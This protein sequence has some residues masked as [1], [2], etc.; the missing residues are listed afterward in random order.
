[1]APILSTSVLFLFKPFQ[2]LTLLSSST[3]TSPSPSP[4][5]PSCSS[6]IWPVEMAITYPH[7]HIIGLD[8]SDSLIH[9]TRPTNFSFVQGN[10][11]DRLPFDDKSFDLVYARSIMMSVPRSRWRDLLAEFTRVTKPG[12]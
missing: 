9:N 3:T 11:L 8:L 2:P 6:A 4:P 1:M 7:S 10:I 5:P 12:G